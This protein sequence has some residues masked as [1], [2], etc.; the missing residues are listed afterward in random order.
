MEMVFTYER[1]NKNKRSNIE[2]GAFKLSKSI[3]FNE[4]LPQEFLG[5]NAVE[6]VKKVS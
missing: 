2:D 5:L 4:G 6:V 3:L 1:V